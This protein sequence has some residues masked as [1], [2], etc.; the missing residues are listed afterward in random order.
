MM[1]I[2]MKRMTMPEPVVDRACLGAERRE[3]H[4]T[5]QGGK[6]SNV[7]K[8]LKHATGSLDCFGERACIKCDRVHKVDDLDRSGRCP[9]CVPVRM[10]GRATTLAVAE[11][12]EG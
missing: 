3:G 8:L 6:H 9:R 12:M 10:P 4:K 7:G 11:Q 1:R 2:T 5:R